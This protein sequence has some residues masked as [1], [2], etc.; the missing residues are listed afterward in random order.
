M[1]ELSDVLGAQSL[2]EAAA[3]VDDLLVDA[4]RPGARVNKASPARNAAARAR[5]FPATAPMPLCADVDELSKMG[6]PF[7]SCATLLSNSND[8]TSAWKTRSANPFR[9][10]MP[11]V[12][13]AT[14]LVAGTMLGPPALPV[15]HD[16]A[17]GG[18]AEILAGPVSQSAENS[19]GKLAR[20]NLERFDE[21]ARARRLSARVTQVFLEMGRL[22]LPPRG[23]ADRFV[24]IP[25]F[26]AVF[27][28]EQ[29]VDGRAENVIES[30][31]RVL[32]S[33]RRSTSSSSSAAMS[34][35]ATAG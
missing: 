8:E 17:Q 2:V 20:R 32:P 22:G 21:R 31:S 18:G 10:A 7:C 19:I 30:R 29:R 14:G 12:A 27:V 16:L 15:R 23:D 25:F 6:G 11:I 28:R 1:L 4:R 34:A 24:R 35:E 3:L 5:I 26:S 13:A 33:C 9:H